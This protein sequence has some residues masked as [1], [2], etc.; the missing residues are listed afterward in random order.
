MFVAPDG[1]VYKDAKAWL[2]ALR[3]RREEQDTAEAQQD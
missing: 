1:E 3:E 2:K